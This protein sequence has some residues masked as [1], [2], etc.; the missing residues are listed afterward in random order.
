MD[1]FL[2]DISVS[3][4]GREIVL[5]SAVP[6]AGRALGSTGRALEAGESRAVRAAGVFFGIHGFVGPGDGGFRVLHRR[7]RVHAERGAN[8]MRHAGM[9]DGG[10]VKV[11][12]QAPGLG[13]RLLGVGAIEDDAE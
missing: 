3:D 7:D 13:A 2:M 12:A 9:D 6:T 5:Y 10:G 11:L 1:S 4:P 8:A